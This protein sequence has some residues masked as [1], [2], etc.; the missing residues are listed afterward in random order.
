MQLGVVLMFVGLGWLV[1]R[2]PIAR[3]QAVIIEGMLKLRAPLNDNKVRGME[4]MGLL[5]CCLL[6]LA[7]LAIVLAHAFLG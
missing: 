2:K 3:R 6:F 5:F 7:G 4:I 1:F